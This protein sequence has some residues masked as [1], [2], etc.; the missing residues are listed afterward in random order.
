MQSKFVK[1]STKFISAIENALEYEIHG[2]NHDFDHEVF[3]IRHLTQCPRRI[4]YRS[5]GAPQDLDDNLFLLKQDLIYVKKKW[6]EIFKK[7]PKITVLKEDFIAADTNLNIEGQIDAV[8]RCKKYTGV[9]MVDS[10]RTEEYQLSKKNG[11]LRRQI[12]ELMASMCLTQVS[13]GILICEEKSTNEYFLSHSIIH[14][15]IV[16]TIQKKCESLMECKVFNQIPEKPYD[17]EKAKECL[18][19][20]YKKQCWKS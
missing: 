16:N 12:I 1:K 19:C 4:F 7:N 6:I 17:S 3:N 14:K 15:P 9:L 8:F 13:N 5:V 18:K 10:L 11:G 20:E 2:G